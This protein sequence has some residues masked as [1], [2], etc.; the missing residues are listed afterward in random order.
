MNEGGKTIRRYSLS[1][2]RSY[3]RFHA[4]GVIVDTTERASGVLQNGAP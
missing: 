2:E 3:R 4:V 1:P